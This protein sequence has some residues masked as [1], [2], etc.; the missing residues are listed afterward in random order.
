MNA[1]PPS[2]VSEKEFAA[3][4]G[5]TVRPLDPYM[6]TAAVCYTPAFFFTS[7]YDRQIQ[8]EYIDCVNFVEEIL[9]DA[10]Q[11]QRRKHAKEET[12]RDLG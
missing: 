4:N 9:T 3:M 2:A 6:Q 11:V 8:G 12:P 10:N 7:K 1:L 5:K